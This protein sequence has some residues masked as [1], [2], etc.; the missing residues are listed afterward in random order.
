[1]TVHLIELCVIREVREI[2]YILDVRHYDQVWQRL[3]FG[4]GDS[5][6]KQ[7]E[8]IAVKSKLRLFCRQGLK[9]CHEVILILFEEFE[10]I[11]QSVEIAFLYAVKNNNDT[12]KMTTFE[13]YLWIFEVKH[14]TK[15][16]Q[17][18]L[19]YVCI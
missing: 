10:I 15:Q 14:Q 17:N 12:L 4:V 19:Q 11:L 5:A 1:M 3:C 7:N 2:S 8:D 13:R 6:G 9:S 18:H 16:N